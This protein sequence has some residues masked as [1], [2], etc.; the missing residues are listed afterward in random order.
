MFPHTHA[1]VGLGIGS[2]WGKR[3]AIISAIGASIPDFVV[4]GLLAAFVIKQGVS[5][6]DFVNR[7]E[8][9]INEYPRLISLIAVFHS[10]PIWLLI[11][12]VIWIFW[13]DAKYLLLGGFS[14][15]FLDFLT[16]RGS[17]HNHLWP[18][19]VQPFHSPISYF[20]GWFIALDILVWACVIGFGVSTYISRHKKK[21]L[22]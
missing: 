7:F 6:V 11:S 15:I 12:T 8:N 17:A 4:D 5:P 10:L 21:A 2:K 22:G 1:L 19:N 3:A 18:L 14:H 13:R 16:H 9:F 20:D